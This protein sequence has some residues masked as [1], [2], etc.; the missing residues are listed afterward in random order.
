[1]SRAGREFYFEDEEEPTQNG[2]VTAELRHIDREAAVR[3]AN[4]GKSENYEVEV[5]E[6][7]AERLS[8][9]TG[10]E[11]FRLF[12][13]YESFRKVVANS[14]KYV[15]A[16]SGVSWRLTFL[17]GECIFLLQNYLISHALLPATAVLLQPEEVSRVASRCVQMVLLGEEGFLPLLEHLRK[18]Y[19]F[20]QCDHSIATYLY[21]FSVKLSKQKEKFHVHVP[22]QAEDPTDKEGT[23]AK[24]RALPV[25]LE[26][27][28]EPSRENDIQIM[29][30]RKETVPV[31]EIAPL[32]PVKPLTDD[33]KVKIEPTRKRN[34]DEDL[35]FCQIISETFSL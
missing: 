28:D 5:F 27:K 30:N 35:K 17:L 19:L 23:L 24:S 22:N 3:R 13:D 18:V 16:M 4:A 2:T 7:V 11:I 10:N 6:S 33:A 34:S 8:S 20:S 32:T 25:K 9:L 26:S 1:M 14:S 15:A 21:N 29:V 31:P 12:M